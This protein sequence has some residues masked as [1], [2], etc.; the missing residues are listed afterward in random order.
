M[1]SENTLPMVIGH[2]EASASHEVFLIGQTCARLTETGKQLP[3]IGL[4]FTTDILR[5]FLQG[6][7]EARQKIEAEVEKEVSRSSV[8]SVRASAKRITDETKELFESIVSQ[9]AAISISPLETGHLFVNENGKVAITPEAATFIHDLH[10]IRITTPE[11][12]EAWKLAN[13]IAVKIEQL[14][15]MVEQYGCL[16][17]GNKNRPFQ[18]L[19][20][21]N[22]KVLA[23]VFPELHNQGAF[24]H[25]GI[26]QNGLSEQIEKN[27]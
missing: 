4:S 1:K 18:P 25:H 14:N 27:L 19:I 17:I 15:E 6:A 16:A 11:Q 3:E 21:Q 23:R 5:D 10:A 7:P 26:L 9:F 8:P 12:L 20:N 22:G 2:D 24:R 13:E